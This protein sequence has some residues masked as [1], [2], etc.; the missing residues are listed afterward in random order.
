MALEAT[1][2]LN[3]DA[4]PIGTI[5]VDARNGL[6]YFNQLAMIWMV[7]HRWPVGSSF[8]FNC[9]IHWSKIL[10]CQPS[11]SPVIILS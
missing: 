8:A 11:N 1:W 4:E 3:H 7:R 5:L 2:I 6:N 9:Y 10:L